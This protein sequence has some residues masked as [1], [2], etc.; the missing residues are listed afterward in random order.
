MILHLLF[1]SGSD[2]MSIYRHK[3]HL[4]PKQFLLLPLVIYLLFRLKITF[5][6]CSTVFHS[7]GW[8]TFS[9]DDASSELRTTLGASYYGKAWGQAFPHTE[10]TSCIFLVA[11]RYWCIFGAM[12]HPWTFVLWQGLRSKPSFPIRKALTIVVQLCHN[13]D[14]CS[15]LPT[16]D[17]ENQDTIRSNNV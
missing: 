4:A 8:W 5:A 15:P 6:L 2:L 3:V 14:N 10:S 12:Y 7:Y 16:H 9:K 1:R 17:H 13:C 11:R